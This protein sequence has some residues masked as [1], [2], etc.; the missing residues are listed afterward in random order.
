[1]ED[2]FYLHRKSEAW[3]VINNF[4]FVFCLLYYNIMTEIFLHHSVS[5]ATITSLFSVLLWN[6]PER[7]KWGKGSKIWYTYRTRK[8]IKE[9][10]HSATYMI[11]LTSVLYL[12]LTWN[13]HCIPYMFCTVLY[14]FVAEFGKAFQFAAGCFF[15]QHLHR[16]ARYEFN[17]VQLGLAWRKISTPQNLL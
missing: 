16:L 10:N 5:F 9:S 2:N 17:L 1:M 14:P 8:G 13:S 12:F 11:P 15:E 3:K 6:S 7:V 4:L